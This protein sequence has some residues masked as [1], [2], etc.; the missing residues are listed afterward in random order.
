MRDEK[1]KCRQAMS[2]PALRYEP[3]VPMHQDHRG[4]WV[5]L[6]DYER[7]RA[8][9]DKANK[10]IDELMK[11]VMEVSPKYPGETRVETA[12][13]YVRE[14]ENQPCSGPHSALRGVGEE[15]NA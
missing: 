9:L 13:R 15:D 1:I 7:L 3:S 11:I 6:R 14:R 4:G 8:E 10:R 12:R 5:K 2:E